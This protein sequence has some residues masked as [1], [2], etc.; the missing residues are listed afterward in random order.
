[1]T[2]FGINS[3]SI[4]FSKDNTKAYQ[5]G[6]SFACFLRK[7]AEATWEWVPEKRGNIYF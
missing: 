6:L 5:S 2:F 4:L 1:M 3:T 7:T